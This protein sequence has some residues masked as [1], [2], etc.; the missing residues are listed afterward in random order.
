M[1]ELGLLNFSSCIVQQVPLRDL[2]FVKKNRLAVRSAF[3]RRMMW[4]KKQ[5][6]VGHAH[7]FF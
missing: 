2:S 1:L 4:A 3:Y 6:G 5:E 7:P